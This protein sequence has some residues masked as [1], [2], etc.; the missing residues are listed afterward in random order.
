MLFT[1]CLAATDGPLALAASKAAAG[2]SEAAAGLLGLAAAV[3][4]VEERALPR[5][6]HLRW[7]LAGGLA[8][9]RQAAS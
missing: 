5:L 9:G 4:A 7:G 2:H 8:C 3:L 6:L 1:A